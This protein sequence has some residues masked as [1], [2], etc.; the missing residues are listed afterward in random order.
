M[1]ERDL[2]IIVADYRVGGT[3]E[4]CY[5]MF[6]MWE[7]RFGGNGCNYRTLGEVLRDSDKNRHLYAEYVERVK[8]IEKLQ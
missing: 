3:D 6:L 2:E 5:Q 1:A 7:Q 4:Q 8:T